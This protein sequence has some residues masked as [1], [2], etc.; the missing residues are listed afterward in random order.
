MNA[1]Q[2]RH[3]PRCATDM[4]SFQDGRGTGW[5][6]PSCGEVICHRTP[7]GYCLIVAVAVIL[8]GLFLML[9][10]E[11]LIPILTSL[12]ILAGILAV[13]LVLISVPAYVV[14]W[15]IKNK[16]A[17]ETRTMASVVRK[18]ARGWEIDVPKNMEVSVWSMVV[19]RLYDAFGIDRGITIAEWSDCFIT[20][21]TAK[22]ETELAVSEDTYVDLQEGDKGLLVYQGEIFRHFIK[23]YGS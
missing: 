15:L 3:C 9:F 23:G 17:P 5:V 8:A 22:G 18:R 2:I 7:R 4:R 12:M 19:N 20:F 11:S 1:T 16:T 21:D 6:C 10:V 14:Y 13:L